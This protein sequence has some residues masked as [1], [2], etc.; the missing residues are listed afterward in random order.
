VTNWSQGVVLETAKAGIGALVALGSKPA[1]GTLVA[2]INNPESGI[3]QEIIGG[4]QSA[5]KQ[6]L[7]TKEAWDE[8]WAKNK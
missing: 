4:L 8:W 1:L 7:A 6:T 2:S 3:R 5:T